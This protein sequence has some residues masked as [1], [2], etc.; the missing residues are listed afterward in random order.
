M[1]EHSQFSFDKA[2]MILKAGLEGLWLAFL[3]FI[4]H[5]AHERDTSNFT[6]LSCLG[7]ADGLEP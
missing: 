1:Y 2:N 4:G 6:G 3:C 5:N 7:I